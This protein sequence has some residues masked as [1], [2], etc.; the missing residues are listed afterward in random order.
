MA[1]IPPAESGQ[2]T[3]LPPPKPWIRPSM[4]EAIT[5][6]VAVLPLF[7]G[8][9]LSWWPVLRATWPPS[10]GSYLYGGMIVLLLGLI[11]YARR[12]EENLRDWEAIQDREHA[13]RREDEAKKRH[14]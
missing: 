2:S 11:Y 9:P 4:L 12:R 10:W 1:D 3:P 13:Q 14:E 7:R 5:A 6:V 8:P